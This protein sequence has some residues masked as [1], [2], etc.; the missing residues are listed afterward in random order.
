MSAIE[1]PATVKRIIDGD[2]VEVEITIKAHVRLLDCW[3]AERNCN[4]GKRA[5]TA[6]RELAL[7]E[8][9]TLRIPYV[10][11]GGIGQLFSFERLLGRVVLNDGTD[12][13]EAMIRAG[14]ATREKA[15]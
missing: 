11:G 8:P 9:G 5:A 7:H 6:L 2:T 13:S 12:L 14:H 1:V 4:E 3:A 10:P 15:T